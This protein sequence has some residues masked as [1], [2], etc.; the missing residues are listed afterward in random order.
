MITRLNILNEV[1]ENV[2]GFNSKEMIIHEIKS[3]IEEAEEQL[4]KD[5]IEMFEYMLEDE[6][7]SDEEKAEIR[8]YLDDMKK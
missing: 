7:V 1:L 8:K 4:A 2:E 3:M 6:F 5:E